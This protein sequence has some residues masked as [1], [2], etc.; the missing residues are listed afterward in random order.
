MAKQ[1]YYALKAAGSAVI[2]LEED[3]PPIL[4]GDGYRR[5][6]TEAL[7]VCGFDSEAYNM[8]QVTA[9]WSPLANRPLAGPGVRLHSCLRGYHPRGACLVVYAEAR[10]IRRD[11]LKVR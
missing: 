9:H 8:A 10:E 3:S 11:G 2:H 1:C 7:P 4:L 6:R 5:A